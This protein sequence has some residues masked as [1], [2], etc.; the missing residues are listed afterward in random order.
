MAEPVPRPLCPLIRL[1]PVTSGTI[2]Q[3]RCPWPFD[4]ARSGGLPAKRA[5]QTP[6][7]PTRIWS[8]MYTGWAE[9]NTNHRV[10]I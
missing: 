1:D 8:S 10:H 3:G 4:P 6:H 7:R 9:G 2:F 5:V